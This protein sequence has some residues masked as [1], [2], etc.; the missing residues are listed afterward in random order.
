MTTEA[1]YQERPGLVVR[2][3]DILIKPRAEWRRI[4]GEE[5]AGL[6]GSYIAPLALGGGLV[7]LAAHI[8]Y[9]GF[10]IGPN[11][12]W[13]AISAAL[14]V[15]LAVVGVLVS[16]FVINVLAPR[17][18]AA[19]NAEH[20]KRLAVYSATPILVAAFAAVAP[21]VAGL[22]AAAGVVYALVL[23]ALGVQPLMP[24]SD[25]ENNVPRLTLTYAL[26][27]AVIVGLAATFAGPLLHSG[28]E[29]L[30]SAVETVAPAP[31]T[32]QMPSRSAAE[33]AIG[34]LSEEYSSTL[35]VDPARL[36][37]QFPDSLPGG[38]ARQSVATAQRGGVSRADSVYRDGAAT[39][40]LAIIQF[41][42]NVDSAALAELL[43]VKPDGVVESGYNRSQMIDGRFYAE[44]VGPN[45]S[46]YIVIGR[47]VIMI[48]EGAVTM[49]QARA[50]VETV[51]LQRLEAMLRR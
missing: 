43:D 32:Q 7:G 15:V 12:A 26:A 38:F 39:L 13:P 51:G 5:P 22:V 31:A 9:G 48:A 46:R 34:R 8:A 11:L 42:S 50:G 28:R 44:E 49:D 10:A 20:A 16:A 40:R 25:P 18:G 23:V 21:P 27:I 17:F 33:I 30:T 3:R 6:I 47:G 37:E 35:L 4:A 45:T 36:A 1:M 29:A 41:G 24:V 19:A 2:A 14:Y